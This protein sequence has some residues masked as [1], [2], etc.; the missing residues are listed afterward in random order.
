VRREREKEI[1]GF[2]FFR[3]KVY[4]LD[5]N[6]N[7]NLLSDF[8]QMVSYSVNHAPNS[9]HYVRY[10]WRRGRRLYMT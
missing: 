5:Q 3:I 1:P 6:N 9:K 4:F 7:N 10:Y 8:A 2:G